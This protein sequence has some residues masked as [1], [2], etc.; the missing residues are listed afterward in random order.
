M[1]SKWPG[2]PVAA[3]TATA[4]HETCSRVCALLNMPNCTVLK[5]AIN[6]TNLFLSAQRV[7]MYS[8]ERYLVIVRTVEQYVN[9]GGVLIFCERKLECE[10][11]CAVLQRSIDSGVAVYH[12]DLPDSTKQEAAINFTARRVKILVCTV[13]FGLGVDV[14]NVTTVIHWGCPSNMEQYVQEIGRAGRTG[15]H[16][17]CILMYGEDVYSRIVSKIPWNHPGRKQLLREADIM[18]SYCGLGWKCRH[19]FICNVFGDSER[20]SCGSNCDV[21]KYG[22]RS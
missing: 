22:N 1:R 9:A 17:V 19:R 18:Q 5:S 7:N 20:D 14:S 8:P 13:A 16:A 15:E 12:S 3:V 21:C 4:T 6:R 2:V 10:K 11:L